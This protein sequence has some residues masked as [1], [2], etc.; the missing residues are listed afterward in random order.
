MAWFSILWCG[1]CDR[2]KGKPSALNVGLDVG[3]ATEENRGETSW[4]GSLLRTVS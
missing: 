3:V 4:Q 1:R 2:I